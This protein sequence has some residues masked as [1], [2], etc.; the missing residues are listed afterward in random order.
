MAT[1]RQRRVF[2]AVWI[3]YFTVCMLAFIWPFA[4]V[5]NTIEPR[6]FGVPFLISWFLIWVLVIFAGSVG[7]YLWDLRMSPRRGDRRG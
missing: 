4:S 3:T 6:I 2:A 5:A 1:K 7:M